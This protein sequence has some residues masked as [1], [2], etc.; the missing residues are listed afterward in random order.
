MPTE[1]LASF[2]ALGGYLPLGGP[3]IKRIFALPG[4]TICRNHLTVT[5]DGIE[6]GTARE[7]DH[8]GRWLPAW[9]GC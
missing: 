3:L 2:L 7:R 4:Q 1:P 5:V 9:E 6:M 8:R